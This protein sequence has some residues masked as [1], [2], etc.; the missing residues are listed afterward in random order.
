LT[1]SRPLLV[2]LRNMAEPE[3]PEMPKWMR[4]ILNRLRPVLKAGCYEV[5]H[6]PSGKAVRL[7]VTVNLDERT[8]LEAGL[9]N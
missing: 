1:K 4:S 6:D 7:K 8:A 5:H 9:L 3:I 2:N